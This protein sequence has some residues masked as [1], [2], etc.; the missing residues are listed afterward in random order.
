MDILGISKILKP[1]FSNV[2]IGVNIDSKSCSLKLTRIKD[3]KI[4]ETLHKEFKTIDNE[5][6]IEAVKFIR[7]YQKKYP[8]TYVSGVSKSYNQGLFK[9]EGKDD[10]SKNGIDIKSTKILNIGDWT[11]Y[12]KESA[13][14]ENIE[15]YSKINGLDHLF[16]P[17][18]LIYHK[19][20]EHIDSKTNLYI[21]QERSNVSLLIAD[22]GGIYFGGYFMIE[23]E[24]QEI[25]EAPQEDIEDIFTTSLPSLNHGDD[26]LDDDIDDLEDLDSDFFIE[27]L[28]EKLLSDNDQEN[29]TQDKVNDI[30]KISIISNIIQNSLREFYSNE[31]YDSKFI[32]RIV[33]LDA[34]GISN[35]ALEHL[36]ENLMI[37][38]NKISVSIPD[39]LVALSKI[40]LDKVL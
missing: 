6:P 31:L 30:A 27:K 1:F 3:K 38:T 23:G 36:K 12:I 32:D 22:S 16:S 7:G 8:F 13:L 24:V 14:R 40:E 25:E 2:I 33:I 5:L 20:N 9:R 29:N 10:F 4:L 18:V 11:V 35:A 26:D 39:E 34:Y 17:F 15:K 21:L 37:E 28:N 19:I